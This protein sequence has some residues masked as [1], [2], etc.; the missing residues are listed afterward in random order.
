[1]TTKQMRSGMAA[2]VVGAALLAWGPGAA[3]I[4]DGVTG[5]ESPRVP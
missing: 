5:W 2:L 1:M 4:N 3:S